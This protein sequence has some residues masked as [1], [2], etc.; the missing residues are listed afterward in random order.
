MR[1]ARRATTARHEE[2]RRSTPSRDTRQRDLAARTAESDR[3]RAAVEARLAVSMRRRH[4]FSFFMAAL[5]PASFASQIQSVAV[6]WQVFSIH[7]DPLDLGLVG[8]AAFLPTVVLALLAGHVADRYDRRT[9]ALLAAAG[10]LVS[11]LL[12]VALVLSHVDSVGPYL[13]VILGQG[14]VEA[15]GSPAEGTLL[16][17]IVPP[18]RYLPAAARYSASRQVVVV[19]GPA[20]GGALIVFGAAA[21]FALAA[22]FSAVSVV[23]FALLIVERR[24]RD[25]TA[26]TL[27]DA[28]DGVRFIFARKKLVGAMSLDLVAV[29]FGGATALLPVFA[30]T[31]LH[32][33]PVGLGVLRSAPAVGAAL[34]GFVLSR[35]PPRRRIGRTLLI[36]V[37]GFGA[38]TIVFGL[39]TSPW[40]SLAALV[41]VGGTDMVSMVIRDGLT[42][43]NTPD[44]MR[45]RVN[46][47]EGVFIGAS[48]QLGAF[49]S[50]TLAAAVGAVPAVV[51]G[52]VATLAVIA[53]WVRYFPALVRADRYVDP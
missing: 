23:A 34:T 1:S 9:I 35:R 30:D 16:V 14:I 8:L 7:H 3:R 22:A 26:P 45:G 21:A 33:G 38:A 53:L 47:A 12:L 2:T 44:A 46:A 25:G 36:A 24:E 15:F 18:E 32:W 20:M 31:V 41:V 37:A 29:L 40:L 50:G 49:E 42:Q 39:S 6:A 4:A 11:S 17:S 51:V 43:L 19:A 10:N 27:R 28:L 48:N 52:G 5:L 13:L